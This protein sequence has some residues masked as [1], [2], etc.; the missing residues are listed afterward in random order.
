MSADLSVALGVKG[1]AIE[2]RAPRVSLFP[3]LHAA[4]GVAAR[5]LSNFLI[6]LIL[7]VPV[8]CLQ[9]YD[10]AFLGEFGGYPDE[11]AHYVTGLMFRDY[12]ASLHYFSPFQFAEN[13][14]VH[15][16][17]VGIGHWPPVFYVV[18]AF[19]TLIFSTSRAS[20]MVLMAVFS[21]L[22]A[23]TL[24]TILKDKLGRPVALAAA[25]I[26]VALP[27]VQ[28]QAG[29]LMAD[30]PVAFFSLL[31]AWSFGR[32]LD[33]ER[34]LDALRFGAFSC[35]A[36]MTKGSGFALMLVPL[37]AIPLS[38]KWNLVRRPAL[39][40]SA[41]IVLTV[42]GPWY[43]LTRRMLSGSWDSVHS[44][45]FSTALFYVE[46]SLGILGWGLTILAVVGIVVV[47]RELLRSPQTNG[48]WASLVGLA[49]GVY[50]LLFVV[51]TG[52]EDRYLLPVIPVA[53][54]FSAMGAKYIASKLLAKWPSAAAR[55]ASV[56]LL[57]LCFVFTGLSFPRAYS[58]GYGA[59]AKMLVSD[60]VLDRSV[61]LVSSDAEG[62]GMLISE[63][64]MRDRRPGHIV[65][66]AS[67]VLARSDWNGG[68]YRLFYS[69]PQDLQR[70]L[71]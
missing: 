22:L 15:Y 55:A 67:E 7:F 43:W 38:R 69:S 12:F 64:A 68:N 53:V 17:K 70:Y 29:M 23:F 35:V 30:I 44:S 2:P 51:P 66:R 13:Y 5:F 19:W 31:A 63:I 27:T 33:T 50:I 8:L 4:S 58:R 40:A 20:L 9:W 42:C 45:S 39:W 1:P 11:P 34:S 14:Y 48:M 65:L 60:P 62:E 52:R 49:A 36:I 21:A 59:V 28:A 32:F 54:A 71:E 26:L 3:H 61:I 16:P 57:V 46:H 47:F 25:F 24:Y 37:I 6:W 41:A 18:E 56:A 10:H